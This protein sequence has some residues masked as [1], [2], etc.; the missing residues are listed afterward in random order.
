MSR[1][2]RDGLGGCPYPWDGRPRERVRWRPPM[3]I[4]LPSDGCTAQADGMCP[5]RREPVLR[6]QAGE[7]SFECPYPPHRD[8]LPRVF[9]R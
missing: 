9:E 3:P 5:A 4:G 8:G 7:R 6:R 1:G 2:V